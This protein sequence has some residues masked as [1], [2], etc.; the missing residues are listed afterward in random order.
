ME[1][2]VQNLEKDVIKSIIEI[3]GN[4]YNNYPELVSLL[5]DVNLLPEQ[6]TEARFALHMAAI[7]EAF[8]RGL[9]HKK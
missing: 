1:K 4:D 3:T 8:K 7:V 5:Y 6:I 2:L 9:N